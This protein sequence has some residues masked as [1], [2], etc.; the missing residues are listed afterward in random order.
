MQDI[1]AMDATVV[2]SQELKLMT[3]CATE[4]VVEISLLIVEDILAHQS[5]ITLFMELECKE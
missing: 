2:M 1:S 5:I 3:H 4:L